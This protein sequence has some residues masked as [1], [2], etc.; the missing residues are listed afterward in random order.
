MHFKKKIIN[1]TR[2]EKKSKNSI[3]ILVLGLSNYRNQPYVKPEK[4]QKF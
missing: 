2:N 4:L 1:N 3:N